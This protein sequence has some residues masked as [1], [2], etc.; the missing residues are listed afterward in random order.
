V[1]VGGTQVPLSRWITID[2]RREKRGKKR[3]K[4]KSRETKQRR[5]K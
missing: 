3:E 4:R 1:G 2:R 5:R